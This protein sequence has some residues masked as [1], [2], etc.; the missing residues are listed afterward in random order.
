[1]EVSVSNLYWLIIARIAG[2]N[3]EL[4]ETVVEGLDIWW[5]LFL[6]DDGNPTVGRIGAVQVF[7]RLRAWLKERF[8]VRV[9]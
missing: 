7:I 9:I 6:A 5:E 8:P 1:M 4:V 2:D 3:R